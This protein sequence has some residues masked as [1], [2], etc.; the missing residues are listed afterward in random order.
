VSKS[1]QPDH[2]PG[3]NLRGDVVSGFLVFLIALPLCLGIAKA[4]GFPEI[5]GV[6]TAIVGGLITPW[7]SN[8]Q[9]T[10][11][12]PAAGLIV[13][14]LGAM[15]EFGFKANPQSP[16]EVATNFDAYRMTLAVGVVAAVI[17]I[18]FGL[19]RAGSLGD[20]FPSAAVH[21]LLA[22]IGV[23]IISKQLPVAIGVSSQGEPLELLRHMHEKFMHLNPEIATIGFV[24]LLILF[25]FPLIKNPLVKRVPVQLIVLCIAIP[26][27]LYFD[28]EHKHD[29]TV[30]GHHFTVDKSFLVNLPGNLTSAITTP[31]FKALLLPGAWIWIAMFALIGSL[32]SL[33]SAKAID[34]LDDK[35]RNT[36][37]N[38][39][40]LAIGVGN[41]IAGLIGG[42]PMISEIVRSRANIDNG[43]KS[44][45]ANMFHGL[46]LLLAVAFLAWAIRMIPMAA[47]AAMLVYTGFRLAHPREFMHVYRIGREQLVVFVGTIVA[48]L[49]TDLLKGIAI[50]IGIELLIQFIHGV[51]IWSLVWPTTQ[52][53]AKGSDTLLIEPQSS[54]VFFNWLL[55][56][57]RIVSEGLKQGKNV[58]L[59][60]SSTKLVDHTV[61]EKLEELEQTFE[62]QGLTLEVVGLGE[63]IALSAHPKAV[64]LRGQTPARC[65]ESDPPVV[66]PAAAPSRAGSVAQSDRV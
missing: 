18:A 28:L 56:R 15:T 46:F 22:A 20:F 61:M 66:S 65:S 60:L 55:I 24:S 30:L 13:I 25:L 21:G 11:N 14:V 38:R 34:I 52:V 44:K 7:I 40:V 3:G 59:D 58:V 5:A 27:A 42:L 33:L 50:G 12:G 57:R 10:I 54:A 17:Q 1:V 35:K 6:F 62:A 23:I 36:D 9:L 29:Y 37:L 43:A 53:K 2:S 31:D 16:E 39:D 63:H 48:V 19:L 32:E 41:L 47:L 45:F 8:S 26:L 51:P 49:A 4:S 64:R